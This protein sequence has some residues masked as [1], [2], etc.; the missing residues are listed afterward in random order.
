[1]NSSENLGSSWRARSYS[2]LIEPHYFG[3]CNRGH[4]RKA[5]PVG[6]F[7]QPSP[8]KSPFPWRATTA[9]LPFSETT[10]TL[11]SPPRM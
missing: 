3:P 9:S 2:G 10:V 7:R 6:Q 8:K 11:H 1:M 4:R 5:T